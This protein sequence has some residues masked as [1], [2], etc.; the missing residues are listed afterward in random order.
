LQQVAVFPSSRPGQRGGNLDHL[1]D[2]SYDTAGLVRRSGAVN[3]HGHLVAQPEVRGRASI[4][5]KPLRLG[6]EWR[7]V[8]RYVV[9]KDDRDSFGQA[10]AA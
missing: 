4:Q 10:L 3:P 5:F 7:H 1:V 2:V 6:K 9:A 8:A